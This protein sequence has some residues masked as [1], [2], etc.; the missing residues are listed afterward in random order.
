MENKFKFLTKHSLNKKLK[1]K[2]FLISNII[3]AIIIVGIVNIDS[4]VKYFGG[5]FNDDIKI[6]IID[7]KGYYSRIKENLSLVKEYSEGSKIVIKK[8]KNDIEEAKKK[9]K[10]G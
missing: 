4:I 3:V 2:L 10:G 5:D 8:E 6:S 9:L 1:N 7:N